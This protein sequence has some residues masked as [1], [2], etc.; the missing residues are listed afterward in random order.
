MT[1][2]FEIGISNRE[3]TVAKNSLVHVDCYQPFYVRNVI[4][5]IIK[6]VQYLLHRSARHRRFSTMDINIV[7]CADSWACCHLVMPSLFQDAESWIAAAKTRL[8]VPSEIFGT[9]SIGRFHYNIGFAKFL[10]SSWFR[11]LQNQEVLSFLESH[12]VYDV[13]GSF[14]GSDCNNLLLPNEVIRGALPPKRFIKHILLWIRL[15]Q[16]SAVACY[17]DAVEQIGVHLNCKS[18]LQGDSIACLAPLCISVNALSVSL[19]AKAFGRFSFTSSNEYLAGPASLINH[20]CKRHSNVVVDYNDLEVVIDVPRIHQF[21][22]LYSTYNTP[23]EMFLSRGIT[24][25]RCRQRLQ[26]S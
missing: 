14:W 19:Q 18:L 12:W 7:V 4:K 6:T 26:Y 23:N 11:S 22:R 20:A 1:H 5:N 8:E 10:K 2:C 15:L 17:W 3:Q 21:D 24:C 16:D 13:P 25:R 9:L